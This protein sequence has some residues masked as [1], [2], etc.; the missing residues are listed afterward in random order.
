[1]ADTNT[2]N[3]SLVKPE[4]SASAD[5][6][7]TKLNADLDAIDAL[8]DAGPALKVTKGGTGAITATAARTNLGVAIGTNVQAWDADLDAIAALAGTSG[9]LRKTA[10][11]TWALETTAYAPLAA[12]T[13]T[14]VPAAPT[15]AVDTNT[16]QLATT[17]FV[18][19]QA[20]A[21]TPVVDGTATIGTSLRYARADHVHPTDTSRAPLAAP[22]FTGVPA[23]PTAAV[24]TST[25]Q[26]ATTAYVVAQAASATPLINGTAAV[27]TSLRYARADHVH[28]TDTSRAPLASPSLTG[29]PLSTTAAV[30]TNTTQI[31]TTAFVVAQASATT[32]VVDGTAAIGTSLRYARA[33]HVH[34]TDTSRAPLASPGLTGTPTAPTAA[35][36]TSTTQ[37]ATT[38]YVV[39]QGYLKSATA[40]GTY[41]TIASLAAYA[42][43]ASPAFTGTPSLPTG[44]TAVTQTAGNNTTAVATTAF[45]TA[46][47]AAS[48]SSTTTTYTSGS[49]NYTIP[50]GT[51]FVYVRLWGAGGSGN[52]YITTSDSGGGGGAYKE[53]VYAASALGGAGASVAYAVGAGGASVSSS[54]TGNPGGNTSFGSLIAYGGSGATGSSNAGTGGAYF[55][56]GTGTDSGYGGTAANGENASVPWGG[57]QG[58]SG[59]ATPGGQAAYGGG[60]GGARGNASATNGGL[61][62]YGGRGGNCTTGSAGEAGQAPGG[63]GAAGGGVGTASGA[64]GAGRIEIWTW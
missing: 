57:A 4:V 53:Y 60:G 54:A 32:P 49:G 25:T 42:P 2:T 24:D 18:V 55:N 11:N 50:T 35:V 20:S 14:G 5:T 33:D 29:T 37:L 62:L 7:G 39:N 16:T 40:S 51:T 34:P 10:A 31:A 30:D 45:V 22:T 23:A 47:V 1:M 27:G 15:A 59:N 17:A 41:A 63:G 6:W 21:T 36:D 43:L 52:T 8:F 58:G 56:A 64:G 28:P 26:L 9:L 61:S 19:A 48:G 12:P 13:F 38:A 46:A 3:L 44:T